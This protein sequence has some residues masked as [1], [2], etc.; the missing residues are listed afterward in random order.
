M[1]LQL[2]SINSSVSMNLHKIQQIFTHNESFVIRNFTGENGTLLAS[3]VYLDILI[4][5]KSLNHHMI[6]KIN[7]DVLHMSEFSYESMHEAIYSLGNMQS[8]SHMEQAVSL[9]TDAGFVVF[10]EGHTEALGMLLPGYETRPIEE[11]KIEINVRG[12]RESFTEDL[13]KNLSMVYRKLKTSDLKSKSYV[14]G[15][16]S[17]TKVMLLYLES[18]V[19]LEQLHALQH[20]LDSIQLD[21]VIANTQIEELIQGSTFSPFPQLLTTERPDRVATALTRGKIAIVTDGTPIALITPTT[22]FEMLHPS[23]DLYERFYFANFLRIIRLISL[24]LSLFGPSLYIALTTFHLEMIPTPLMMTFISSK[25]GIPFPTFVE[26]LLMETSFELLREASLRLPRA[27]GQSVSI[28]GALI[29]GEAAVQSGIVS[30]PMV[31]VVAM[32][33]I[34]SFAIPSFST[35]IA[36]R[37]LR[38]PLMLFAA[39]CGVFGLSLSLFIL[40]LHLCSIQTFGIPFLAVSNTGSSFKNNVM[41][42]ILL[43]VKYRPHTNVHTNRTGASHNNEGLSSDKIEENYEKD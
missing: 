18:Q 34:A 4:D 28:V 24:F 2:D 15:Q 7:E 33:G 32:T 25:A 1:E 12:P 39:Y 6:R 23:E 35:A 42:Y 37:M 5:E 11:P 20:K 8:I 36:I 19:N 17:N 26:A 10:I 30:R 38:F 13:H 31:I 16:K 22:F 9:M 40:I 29:I 14:M 41:K 21:F 43:P 3:I 27:V